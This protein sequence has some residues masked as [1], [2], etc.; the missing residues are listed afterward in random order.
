MGIGVTGVNRKV[1]ARARR[2]KRVRKRV[3]GTPERPRLSVF[4]SLRHTYAQII[5]DTTGHTL[6]SA[7]TISRE[8]R[9]ELTRTGNTEAAQKVGELIARK[10]IEKGI[11]MVIFDRNGYLYHG[12]VRA[13]AEAARKNGLIF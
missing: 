8:I 7:S 6:V 13:L 5:V 12:R 2:R 11:K 3:K 9:G 1:E 4:R 10:S